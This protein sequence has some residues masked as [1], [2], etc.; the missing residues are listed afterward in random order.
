MRVDSIGKRR[1]L[2]IN[3]GLGT[4]N[5]CHWYFAGAIYAGY[6]QDDQWNAMMLA[7]LLYLLFG[8]GATVS[9]VSSRV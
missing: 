9:T 7:V 4:L 5:A 1:V 6:A 8:I 3:N 2:F